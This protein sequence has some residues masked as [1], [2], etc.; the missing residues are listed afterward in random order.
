MK[1]LLMIVVLVLLTAYFENSFVVVSQT[2]S[3]QPVVVCRG[4]DMC[5]TSQ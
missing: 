1:Y 3:L 2:D 4:S 5:V